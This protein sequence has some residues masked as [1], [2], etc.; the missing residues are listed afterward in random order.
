[1]RTLPIFA[2]LALLAVSAC[3]MTMQDIADAGTPAGDLKNCEELGF[4]PGTEAMATCMAT[5]A[6]ER[7]AMLDRISEE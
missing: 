2:G 7:Q 6:S 4:E 3:D 5:A 1:M